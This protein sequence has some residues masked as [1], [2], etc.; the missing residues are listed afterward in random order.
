MQTEVPGNYT[1]PTQP[2]PT[3]PEPVDP[4]VLGGIT[5]EFIIDYTPQLEER[6]REILSDFRIGG[7]YVP[8]LP[9]DHDND[10]VNNVGCLGGGNIIPH[11]PVADPTRG[12]M[13][14]SHRRSCSAPV[15]LEPTGGVDE[16]VEDFASPNDAG[17]TPNRTPTTGSTVAAWL[18]GGGGE[19]RLPTIDGLPVWKPMNNQLSSFDMNAGERTWSLP[20]G[21]TPERIREHPLLEDVDVPNTGGA[22]WSIQ[23][24]TGDLLVQTRALSQGTAQIVP[25]APLELHARDPDTGAILSSVDLPAPGQYGMMTYMHEGMQ[26]IVVQVGSVH[27]DFPGSLVAYRLP[28]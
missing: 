12:L 19:G 5:D 11:P 15:F 21:E 23:M 22:G 18:P 13:Y 26:Y 7:L 10:F 20:V 16:E 14:V 6:A 28:E 27:T 25:D 2:Y 1:S 17:A 4:I 8:P 24:V 9:Y 3:W